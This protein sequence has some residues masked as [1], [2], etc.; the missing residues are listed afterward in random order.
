MSSLSKPCQGPLDVFDRDMDNVFYLEETLQFCL[1][2]LTCHPLEDTP[3][4]F[5]SSF[6]VPFSD[7]SYIFFQDMNLDP[8]KVNIH[9]G[10]VSL[11]HPIG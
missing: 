10:A 7:P 4:V 6:S 1:K 3:K 11:G 2:Y 9:G 8:T 5:L